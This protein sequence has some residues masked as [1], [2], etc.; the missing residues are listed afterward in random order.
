[1]IKIISYVMQE[2]CLYDDLTVNQNLKMIGIKKE[3]FLKYYNLFVLKI[4]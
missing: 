1:M 2:A 4:Q 3:A